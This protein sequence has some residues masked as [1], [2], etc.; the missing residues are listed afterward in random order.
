MLELRPIVNTQ[1]LEKTRVNSTDFDKVDYTYNLLHH[2]R[3]IQKQMLRSKVST[4]QKTV[5]DLDTRID[6]PDS[7][8]KLE[9]N[10]EHCGSAVSA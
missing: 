8:S 5:D 1:L 6:L 4:V 7:C 2:Y 10:T 3:K 9:S